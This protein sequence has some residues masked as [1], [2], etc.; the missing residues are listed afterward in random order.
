MGRVAA[1]LV[2]L[3]VVAC[4]RPATVTSKS[5]PN[6][7]GV[8]ARSGG[9]AAAA[10]AKARARDKGS[11]SFGSSDA[12]PGLSAAI[13]SAASGVQHAPGVTATT[14]KIGFVGSANAAALAAA[15]GFKGPDEGNSHEQIHAAVDW[16]N[17]HGGIAGRR[18]VPI[19]R[20]F[21]NTSEKQNWQQEEAMCAGFTEDDHVFAVVG[22][23]VSETCYVKHHTLAMNSYYYQP[24]RATLVSYAPYIWLANLPDLSAMVAAEIDGLARQGFFPRGGRVGIIV[25]DTPAYRH[26]YDH[27]VVPRLARIGVKPTATVFVTPFDTLSDASAVAQQE[28]AAVLRFKSDHIDHVFFVFQG[29]GAWLFFAQA[30]DA[31][32]YTPRYGLSSE[33]EPVATGENLPASQRHG[34]MGVGFVPGL[35]VNRGDPF[36]YTAAEKR[37]VAAMNTR[38]VALSDRPSASQAFGYCDMTFILWQAARSVGPRLTIER[39]AAAAARMGNAFQAANANPGGTQFLPSG[40]QQGNRFYRLTR[41]DDA[42]ACWTYTDRNRTNHPMPL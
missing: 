30:A 26:L 20:D 16:V 2:L 12:A 3:S 42:C 37:C 11:S 14:V 28:N 13:A 6:A 38:G 35:D 15:F 19:I 36:P 8:A 41:Y 9:T 10:A 24:D 33:D 31:Q 27:E 34:A 29:G 7:P 22:T 21:D 18:I 4:G 1:I 17:K 5:A 40:P 32:R 23:S 25:R 39:W